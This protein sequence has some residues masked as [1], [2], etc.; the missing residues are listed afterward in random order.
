LW[1]KQK[2]T[3]AL[4]TVFPSAE[5]ARVAQ[6]ALTAQNDLALQREEEKLLLIAPKGDQGVPLAEAISKSAQGDFRQQYP[7]IWATMRWLPSK[8][9]SP[10]IGVG[11]IS[12]NE[13]MLS[14]VRD[15][16]VSAVSEFSPTLSG[17]GVD[18]VV[19]ALYSDSAPTILQDLSK[20]RWKD[21]GATAL[22]VA[23]PTL[24]SFLVAQLLTSTA[25]AGALS[26]VNI[27]SKE[28]FYASRDGLHVYFWYNGAVIYMAVSPIQERAHGLLQSAVTRT[29]P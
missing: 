1:L 10:P 5:E 4:R 27:H 2:D 15:R 22:V 20:E 21:W 9:I 19:M 25:N 8:P 17:L 29:V 18:H 7:D 3:Y 6:E 14:L 24:P 12:L 23:K 28:A 16:G 11:F 13:D 26:R